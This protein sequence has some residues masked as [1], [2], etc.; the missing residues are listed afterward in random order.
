M[1]SSCLRNALLP[2]LPAQADAALKR[3]SAVRLTG[4]IEL[5][6]M[7]QE[8]NPGLNFLAL[9]MLHLGRVTLLETG[10]TGYFPFTYPR[11]TDVD[12]AT[13]KPQAGCQEL[14]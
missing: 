5:T 13:T 12:N 7:T 11:T 14:S 1:R 6:Q 2:S 4:D 8:M 3:F 10:S 9:G